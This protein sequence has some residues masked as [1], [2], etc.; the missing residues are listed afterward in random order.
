LVFP[1]GDHRA[2]F[3]L[4]IREPLLIP[5]RSGFN[6]FKG[7][8]NTPVLALRLN[9]TAYSLRGVIY[10]EPDKGHSLEDWYA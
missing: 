6:L 4:G 7:T 10:I 8:P 3:V 2:Q 1:D 5:G 9:F